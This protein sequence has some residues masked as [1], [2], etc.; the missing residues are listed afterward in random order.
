MTERK[1][2]FPNYFVTTF[3]DLQNRDLGQNTGVVRTFIFIS[4]FW[5][6]N[7]QNPRYSHFKWFINVV[8]VNQLLYHVNIKV[9]LICWYCYEDFYN[10]T[11]NFIFTPLCCEIF[12][13]LLRADVFVSTSRHRLRRFALFILFVWNFFSSELF[14]LLESFWIHT[15]FPQLPNYRNSSLKKITF[16]YFS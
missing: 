6:F 13:S 11:V 14:E 10:E 9:L 1:T 5:Q 3:W 16:K 2:Q 12:H 8:A 7:L 15:L 4:I